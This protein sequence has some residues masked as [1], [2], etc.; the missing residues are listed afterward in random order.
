M[1]IAQIL[2]FEDSPAVALMAPSDNAVSV[3]NPAYSAGRGVARR[4]HP[5]CQRRALYYAPGGEIVGVAGVD[6]GNPK[7]TFG[8]SEAR[9]RIR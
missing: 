7:F 6:L 3:R 1:R 4:L 5:S 9:G 2:N 8:E